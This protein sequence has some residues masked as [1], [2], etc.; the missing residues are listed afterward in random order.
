[1][2]VRELIQGLSDADPDAVVLIESGN[3]EL[4]GASVKV[5][6]FIADHHK[7]RT[8]RFRDMMDYST[9]GAEVYRPTTDTGIKTIRFY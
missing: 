6:G 5:R 4:N 2:T 1:M 8:E 7:K 3:P 9:Y